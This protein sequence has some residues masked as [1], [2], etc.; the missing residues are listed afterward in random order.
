[1]NEAETRAEHGLGKDQLI[2]MRRI[3]DADKSDLFDVLAYVA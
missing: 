1:M 2:E 3:I